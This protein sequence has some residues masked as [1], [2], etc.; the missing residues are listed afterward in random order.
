MKDEKVL[1]V[2][3]DQNILAGFK[4][5]LR[6]QFH[7]DTAL[8]GQLG[9]DSIS[10]Q[11]PYAV[12]VSD[13]RM[14]GMDGVEFLAKAK[15]HSPDSA[16][17]LLTGFADVNSAMEAVNEGNIFRF[18]S[19]PC[20]PEA[21]AKA[22]TAGI[23]QYRLVRAEKEL[24]EKTLSGSIKVLTDVLALSNPVAFSRASLIRKYVVDLTSQ[25]GL[26]ETWQF[27]ISSLLSQ[28]GCIT[29][30]STALESL[31]RREPLKTTEK[32]QFDEHPSVGSALIANIPRLDAVAEIV[33]YQEKR[34]DGS[35]VPEDSVKGNDIPLGSRLLKVAADILV[36]ESAGISKRRAVSRLKQRN[37]WYDP[38]ILA[39]M[40]EIA[41]TE[42]IYQPRKVSVSELVPGMII[43][44]DINTQGGVL[45]VGKGNEVTWL[46]CRRLN[47]FVGTGD[48]SGQIQVQIPS[49]L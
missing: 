25:L 17:I 13:L 7:V 44:E 43:S 3:D 4:R 39:A 6:K 23:R 34:Y 24:L 32:R 22:L 2:D 48:I 20:T 18:L 1:C 16:R 11:G 30:P 46:M 31:Y 45:L 49:D 26:A 28:I 8:D 37:G 35:G 40:E 47:N 29:L 42:T 12:I 9:L 14:P 33:A 36:L 27:E 21:L 5:A 38:S 15:E 41:Q 10:K 19:K